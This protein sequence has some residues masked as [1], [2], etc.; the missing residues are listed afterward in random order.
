MLGWEVRE[1]L[2]N[3]TTLGQ[4]YWKTQDQQP[5]LRLVFKPYISET[6]DE[7]IDPLMIYVI[8]SEEGVCS[9]NTPGLSSNQAEHV[10]TCMSLGE[11]RGVCWGFPMPCLLL[12]P[13]VGGGAEVSPQC[14]TRTRWKSPPEG[15]WWDQE[16]L[17]E[18]LSD[19]VYHK[20][21]WIER[22]ENF[23]D[24]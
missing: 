18:S 11:G 7:Y 3:W 21:P 15:I 6:I 16:D 19:S 2:Y 10:T 5:P 8:L 4:I 22:K 20:W 12:N 14:R 17:E 13:P 9:S 24:F 23:L 1:N